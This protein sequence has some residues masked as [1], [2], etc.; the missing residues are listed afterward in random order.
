MIGSKNQIIVEHLTRRW[1]NL[2]KDLKQGELHSLSNYHAAIQRA[3]KYIRLGRTKGNNWLP[4]IFQ[5]PI[6]MWPLMGCRATDKLYD[7]AVEE[8]RWA[9]LEKMKGFFWN[10]AT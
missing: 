7:E 2:P 10:L 8:A 6:L 4:L 1:N 9:R 3:S 5:P